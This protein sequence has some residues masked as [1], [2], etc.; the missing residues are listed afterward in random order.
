VAGWGWGL[1]VCGGWEEVFHG[2]WAGFLGGWE[3]L[4][5]VW[6]GFTGEEIERC[7]NVRCWDGMTICR[8]EC[9]NSE[10]AQDR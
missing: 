1:G 9:H 2:L 4:L 7:G 6:L 8:W 3:F 10:I 5:E